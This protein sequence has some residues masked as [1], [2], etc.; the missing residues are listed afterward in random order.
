MKQSGDSRVS[1]T[2][3]ADRL[4]APQPAQPPG[5]RR[6]RGGGRD[7]HGVDLA[8]DRRGRTVRLSPT[9]RR[10]VRDDGVDQR[11]QRCRSVGC[12][13]TVMP[14]CVA[15][16]AVTG[17]MAA[18]TVVRSR[19]AACS[20]PRS[21]AKLRTA[22]ALVNVTTS[23]RAVEQ[24]AGRCPARPRA[25]R[26]RARC[27][28]RSTSVTSA[29]ACAQLVGDHLAADVGARQQHA[30]AV[31]RAALRHARATTA[32]ARNSSGTR[33]T[34]RPY[35]ASRSAVPVPTAHSRGPFSARTS[36]CAV[37][38][39]RHERLDGVGAR[40]DDPVERRRLARHARRAGRSRPAARCGSSAPRSAR[41]RAPRAA[42]PARP[43][44]R[45]AA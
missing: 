30:R 41:R 25:P 39:R 36:R 17:P 28:R 26:P 9:L 1:R 19:S 24:H 2:S 15:A 35:R 11:R 14:S 33:S 23:M 3:D 8:T 21:C 43:P 13:V 6:A 45:A 44:A 18:T 40:E 38:Q 16:S 5:Q 29:P 37:E 31:E 22:D 4:G 20:A 42:R 34:L 10:E 27:G 7:G 12:T 32:S